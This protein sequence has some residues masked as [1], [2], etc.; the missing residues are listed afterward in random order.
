MS[1]KL[2]VILGPS[3]HLNLR[4]KCGL[5]PASTLQ[6]PLGPLPVQNETILQLMN[7][8]SFVL[9][10]R[11]EDEMEHSLEMQFPFIKYLHGNVPVLPIM[12]GR[13]SKDTR[14]VMAQKL[15]NIIGTDNVL[16]VISSDFCHYG[17]RFNYNS[18]GSERVSDKIREMDLAGFEALSTN[19]P[20]FFEEY[21]NAT[22]N[23]ICGREPILL[24]LT[25]ISNHQSLKWKLLSYTQSNEIS[26]S[27]DS[28]VSYL[29]AKL[30]IN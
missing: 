25:M 9:L 20:N 24:F 23:T 2:I 4:D 5:T 15:T 19:N 8:P 18:L 6:T 26:S 21:L 3:H 30:I 29:S 14:R 13:L 16:F 11:D 22:N 10:T 27:S 7:D 1:P 12:V 17:Q 28:S